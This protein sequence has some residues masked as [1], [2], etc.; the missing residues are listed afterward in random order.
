MPVST[1]TPRALRARNPTVDVLRLR[2]LDP[3]LYRVEVDVAG[4]TLVV[5]DDAG[6][7]L[8]FRSALDAK[9]GF[10]GLDVRRAVLVQQSAY[11]EMVGQPV[12]SGSNALEVGIAL[13][14][15]DLS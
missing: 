11:D 13:P 15:D 8:R 14:D 3:A 2:S 12:R 5:V 4:T 9:R 1:I 10:R 7:P 6:H